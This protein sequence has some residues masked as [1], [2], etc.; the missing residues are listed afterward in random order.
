M[1]GRSEG[2]MS[3]LDHLEELRK[4]LFLALGGL[5][6]GVI[7]CYSVSLRIQ[8]FLLQPIIRHPGTT[9]ALLAPTE[10]FIVRLKISLVAGLFVAAPWVFFQLW[11]FVAPGLYDRERKMVL[12]VVFFS[13]LC[14]IAGAVF[15]YLILPWATKF[16]LSFATPTVENVWSL[17][18][19]LDF[20]LRMFLAFGV[21]F[22]LPIVIYFLARLGI[23][24]PDFLR[25]YRRHAYIV[26]LVAAAIITP[27][28]VF[29]QVI[30]AAPMV[31]LYEG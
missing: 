16:F 15:G 21:V 27:P 25:R 14:F 18:R 10:G 17:G 13:T 30:L 24:T 6:V 3:F 2:S 11:H 1:S 26:V 22:E 20:V 28:D 9:L 12:P 29:T 31:V 5:A 19:Y 4:T 8:E 23:V 7:A